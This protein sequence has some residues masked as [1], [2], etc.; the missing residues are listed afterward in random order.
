M[1]ISN[2]LSQQIGLQTLAEQESRLLH[3]MQ[4]LGSN[5][6]VLTPADDPLAASQAVSVAQVASINTRLGENRAIAAHALGTQDQALGQTI[7]MLT[8]VLT[9]VVQSGNGT[10]SS[11]ELRS[12]A[13][14]L[15]EARASLLAQANATDGN[16]QYLFSGDRG[17][18][19]PYDAAGRLS[20]PAPSGSRLIQVSQTRQMASANVAGDIFARVAPSATGYVGEVGTPNAG[21]VTFGRVETTD[22]SVPGHGT[23]LRVSFA[24]RADGGFDVSVYDVA[25]PTTPILGPVAYDKRVVLDVRGVRIPLSGEPV[26]GDTFEFRSVQD[27]DVDMFATL[28][29]LVGALEGPTQ[30]AHDMA[31]LNNALASAN[32]KLNLNFDNLVTAQASVGARLNELDA[33]KDDGENRKLNDAARLLALEEVDI[34]EASSQLAAYRTGLEA[35]QQAYLRIQGLS[36]FNRR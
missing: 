17:E 2:L 25:A 29:Q 27:V 6:R 35:A 31:V 34:R 33:L 14:T 36:L 32:R 10:Y 28:D 21:A 1:R 5:R 11:G 24:Q 30:T 7:T 22:A 26:A 12:L 20:D 13:N 19:A 4:Q 16:G 3:V 9:Q 23:A 15:R 18:L 8:G